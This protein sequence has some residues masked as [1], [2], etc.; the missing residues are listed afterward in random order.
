[1]VA[2]A[3]LDDHLILDL[4]GSVGNSVRAFLGAGGYCMSAFL[5]DMRDL[6]GTFLGYTGDLVGTS[7]DAFA[8]LMRRMLDILASLVCVV[9]HIFLRLSIDA[10]RQKESQKQGYASHKIFH[11]L[12]HLNK[13]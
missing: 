13:E 4:F 10:K 5:G 8:N 9:F 12:F 2:I 7:L 1:M 3:A 11:H 6:M